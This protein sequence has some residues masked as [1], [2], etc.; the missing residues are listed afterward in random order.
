M[1][2]DEKATEILGEVKHLLS[3][4]ADRLTYSPEDLIVRKP[5]GAGDM[6]TP[7][8]YKGTPIIRRVNR[9]LKSITVSIPENGTLE[10]INNNIPVLFFSDESGTIELDKGIDIQDLEIRETNAGANPARFNYT[11]VFG[12]D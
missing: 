2:L 1:R 8:N 10:I 3:R 7:G 11:L 9:R 6:L 12:S 5:S 4:I